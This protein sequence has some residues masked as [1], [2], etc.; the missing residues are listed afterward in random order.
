[1]LPIAIVAVLIVVLLGV[2]AFRLGRMLSEQAAQ[3]RLAQAELVE[4]ANILMGIPTGLTQAESDT[5]AR[6]FELARTRL[7]GI[8]SALSSSRTLGALQHLPILGKQVTSAIYLSDSGGHLAQ[9]GQVL[10]GRLR[11]LPPEDS[12]GANRQPSERALA[13]LEALSPTLPQIIAQ[14][15][16]V[17]RDHQHIATTGLLPPLSRAVRELDVKAN[18]VAL[19]DGIV[20]LRRG[21]TAIRRLLGGEGPQTYMVLQQ[22]PA[23]LRPTGGFIGSVGFLSFDQGRMAPFV[24]VDV[25]S[26]DN[27]PQG[28]PILGPRGTTNHVDMPPPLA[29]AFPIPSW[30][31]RDSNWSPDFPT[32]AR[33]AEFFLQRESGKRV[34]GVVAIDP[35]F[36][37]RL[38][39]AVGPVTVPETGD[40]VDQKNFFAT[41][42]N[43]VEG[44]EGF[45]GK[46]FLAY[47]AK[48]IFARVLTVGPK[49]WPAILEVLQR[50]C[51][52]RSLQAYFHESAREAFI[53][54]YRCGG[55]VGPAPG[56]SLLIVDANLG[57]DKDDFWMK[58]DFNLHLTLR[59][60]GSVR[61]TLTIRHYGLTDHGRLTEYV[62][63]RGWLRVYVPTSSLLV[64]VDGAALGETTELG[65]HVL[66]GW[67]RVPF[68]VTKDITIVYDVAALLPESRY[69]FDLNWQKQAGR[70][71]DTLEVSFETPPGYKVQP[72]KVG[73]DP[74]EGTKV[75]SDLS[76]DRHFE[77]GLAKP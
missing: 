55:E 59:P 75:S 20:K 27:T 73:S 12:A 29:A 9:V 18:P 23:E 26:I 43:N 66:Q 65:L 28:R 40:V 53:D 52:T 2:E 13:I 58:R 25:Y 48:A 64:S 62:P 70:V 60:D 1:M 37:A 56:D 4:G 42:L 35:F 39:A 10:V 47:A 32:A 24:P 11:A 21:E 46:S 77:F 45:R 69:T 38:L 71:A 19:R 7:Y 57:A 31:L 33:Q 8:K 14:L 67:F 6:D 63:Y 30:T 50:G 51:Q 49:K 68:S 76:V 44:P 72:I 15:N 3:A 16:V 54:G 17:S 22:D 36:V 34:D 74:I 5:A 41:T 61:H